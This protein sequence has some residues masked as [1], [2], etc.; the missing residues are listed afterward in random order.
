[1]D[2]CLLEDPA[3]LLYLTGLSVSKGRFLATREGGKFFVD[4]SYFE[5]AKKEAPCPVFLVR[6]IRTGSVQVDSAS[7]LIAPFSLMK[8]FWDLQKLAQVEWIPAPRPLKKIRMVK[9]AEEIEKLKK[10][11][12]SPG[13]DINSVSLLEEGSK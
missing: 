8:D 2:G 10:A 9:E 13:R 7:G 5:K 12:R 11:A 1:M 3:D 6:C 4:G